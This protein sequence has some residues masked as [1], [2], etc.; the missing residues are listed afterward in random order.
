MEPHMESHMS[1]SRASISVF[2]SEPAGHVAPPASVADLLL[3]AAHQHPTSGLNLPRAER[4]GEAIF[5][6]Y[7]ALLDQAQR[8]LGGLQAR[9]HAPGGNVVLLLEHAGDFVPA[10]WACVLGGYV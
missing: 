1:A 6:S 5:L 10:L 2:L 9:G 3:R 7:P 4:N 8:I